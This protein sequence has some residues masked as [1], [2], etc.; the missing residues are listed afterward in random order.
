MKMKKEIITKNNM[1]TA[2]AALSKFVNSD[3]E[4][5][6]PD[7]RKKMEDAFGIIDAS[8]L[9]PGMK[10]FSPSAGVNNC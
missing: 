9:E 8:R 7:F 6:M 10:F 4:C 2:Y 5:S 3:L 1:E